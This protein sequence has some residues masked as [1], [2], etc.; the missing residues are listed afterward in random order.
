MREIPAHDKQAITAL[1]AQ[2]VRDS[3][4]LQPVLSQHTLVP[5]IRNDMQREYYAEMLKDALKEYF[6]GALTEEEID[7]IV[8]EYPLVLADGE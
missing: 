6:E 8:D 2:A 4:L 5:S 3:E 7:A 1:V